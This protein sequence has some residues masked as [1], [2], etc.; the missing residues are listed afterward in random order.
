MIVYSIDFVADL[1]LS[2][3]FFDDAPLVDLNIDKAIIY[4]GVSVH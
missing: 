3:G 1:I 2:G 4:F